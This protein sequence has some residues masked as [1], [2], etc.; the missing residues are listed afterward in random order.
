MTT[1]KERLDLEQ[2]SNRSMRKFVKK[3]GKRQLRKLLM[4][5]AEAQ[6]THQQ[7]NNT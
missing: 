7:N 6:S 2:M 5:K 3:Y 4:A 1:E